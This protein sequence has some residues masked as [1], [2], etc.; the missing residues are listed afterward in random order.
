MFIETK[1]VTTTYTRNSKCGKTHTYTRTQTIVV[2]ECD[3]CNSR[4]ER[5]QGKMDSKRANGN[6]YHVCSNCHPKQFAQKRGVERRKLWNLSADSDI[7]IT[8]I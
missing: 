6:Y 7:N 5:A 4:F 3:E 1:K 2:L 8:K